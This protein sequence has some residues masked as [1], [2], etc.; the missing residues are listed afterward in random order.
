MAYSPDPQRM[1]SR[2]FT[3]TEYRRW[4][5]GVARGFRKSAHEAQKTA[6][7]ISPA[8]AAGPP[9]L[10]ISECAHWARGTL[11]RSI[12][13]WPSL[14]QPGLPAELNV[15]G[16]THAVG[17]I[18]LHLRISGY[19]RD[20]LGFTGARPRIEGV[21]WK[22]SRENDGDLSTRKVRAESSRDELNGGI[23]PD[24]TT[25]H[26]SIPSAVLRTR[27]KV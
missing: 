10:A 8:K 9:S 1:P 25:L 12:L 11:L 14:D 22:P 18:A 16:A 21:C 24:Y 7:R 4:V 6:K 3:E 26:F 5:V 23:P 19:A 2:T 17:E 27:L 20:R 15:S 13:G